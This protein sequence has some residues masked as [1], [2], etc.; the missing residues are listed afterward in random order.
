MSEA[1]RDP[2][3]WSEG[4]AASHIDDFR[5]FIWNMDQLE[6]IGRRLGL[7]P[8]LQLADVGSG[9]GFFGRCFLPMVM[10]GGSL[11]GFELD[12]KLVAEAN[13]RAAAHGISGSARFTQG[14]AMALPAEDDSFD[15]T[16]CQTLLMH[17]PDPRSALAEMI[18]ITKPGGLVVTAEP[19]GL[20]SVLMERWAVEGGGEDTLEDAREAVEAFARVIEGQRASGGGDPRIGTRMPLLMHS[21]GLTGIRAWLDDRM[22]ILHPPYDAHDQ[23]DVFSYWRPAA[24][25]PDHLTWWERFRT[26]HRAAGGDDARYDALLDR[27]RASAREQTEGADRN[28]LVRTACGVLILAAGRVAS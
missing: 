28:A 17:L 23:P 3:D 20:A 27:F 5:R 7:R 1:E 25:A 13:A 10:P 4:A 9:Y 8:G 24:E 12:P 19:D 21:A 18:R 15:V 22:L 14:D 26:E 11:R 2:V 6:L 16:M